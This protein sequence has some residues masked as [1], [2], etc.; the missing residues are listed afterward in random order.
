MSNSVSAPDPGPAGET[1]PQPAAPMWIFKVMNPAMK[2]L[3]RSPL[4][5]LLSSSLMLITYTGPKTGKRYTFPIGYFEWD[6]NELM[7][8]SSARWW[9]HLR[10]GRPVTLLIKGKQVNAIPK[11]IEEREEVLDTLETFIQRLG[12]RAAR[13]LPLGL[14]KDHEPTHEEL[15]AIR[16]GFTLIHFKI[17]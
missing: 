14:P 11:V 7:S 16:G 17:I 13:R 2:G 1:T 8:F 4:H 9:M 15:T 10:D 6:E 5:S 12:M 3:L